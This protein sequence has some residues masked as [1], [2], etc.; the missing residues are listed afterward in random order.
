ME[1]EPSVYAIMKRKRGE[2]GAVFAALLLRRTDAMRVSRDP[3]EKSG[4][5]FS[6]FSFFTAESVEPEVIENAIVKKNTS[7]Y[8]AAIPTARREN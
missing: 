2:F 5:I 4:K 1:S 6:F 7:R 3:P 8:V